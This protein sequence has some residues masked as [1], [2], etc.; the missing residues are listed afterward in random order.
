MIYNRSSIEVFLTHLHYAVKNTLYI[1]WYNIERITEIKL[2]D[3]RRNA[4]KCADLFHESLVLT[5]M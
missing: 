4:S 3:A 1:V 2:R 5:N